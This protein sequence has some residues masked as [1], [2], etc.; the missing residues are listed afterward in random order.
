[1]QAPVSS[2]SPLHP[3]CHLAPHAIHVH[4]LSGPMLIPLIEVPRVLGPRHVREGPSTM[5]YATV[6]LKGG[7]SRGGGGYGITI[8]SRTQCH[9]N[10]STEN[11]APLTQQKKRNHRHTNTHKRSKQRPAPLLLSKTMVSHLSQVDVSR[12]KK[13]RP[14]PVS[15]SVTFVP[16][17][18]L[19]AGARVVRHLQKNEWGGAPYGRKTRAG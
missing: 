17:V 2:S 1:M 11:R 6:P 14:V 18:P 8:V 10:F 13:R 5:P 7:N 12:S 9:D 4:K 15:N 3:I 16:Q 19:F